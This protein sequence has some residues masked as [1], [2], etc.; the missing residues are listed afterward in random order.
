ME[1]KV[2]ADIT[3]YLADRGTFEGA[4]TTTLLIWSRALHEE[5]SLFRFAATVDHSP[6]NRM[7]FT[8]MA[9]VI[10]TLLGPLSLELSSRVQ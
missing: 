3:A 2:L 9:Q 8:R 6:A 1:S 7:E 4:S 5:F 10:K